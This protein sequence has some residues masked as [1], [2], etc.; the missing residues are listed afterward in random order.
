MQKRKQSGF[1]LIEIMVVVVILGLLA[2]LV[3]QAVGDRPD[4]ARE[5]KVRNDLSALESALKMYRLDTMSFPKMKEGLVALVEQPQGQNN[6]RGPYI[7]RLPQDPWG[8]DYLYRVPSQHKHKFDIYT[9]GAD[10]A[11]GGSESDADIGN[12]SLK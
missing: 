5:V 4:Q 7:E 3:I 9:L 12:W 6:W 11:E 10:N 8:N 1:T 2:T